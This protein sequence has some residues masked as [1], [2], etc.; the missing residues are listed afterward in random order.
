MEL[1]WLERPQRSSSPTINPELGPQVPQMRLQL[2]HGIVEVGETSK[3]TQSPPSLGLPS[4]DTPISHLENQLQPQVVPSP[5]FPPPNEEFGIIWD[6]SQDGPPGMVL[7]WPKRR[8]RGGNFVVWG[9]EGSKQP[10]GATKILVFEGK[11]LG[12]LLECADGDQDGWEKVKGEP[13]WGEG[14]QN[15]EKSGQSFGGITQSFE[16]LG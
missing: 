7:W 6:H 2:G 9:K 1:L 13:G 15:E 11:M 4:K 12:M 10:L 14:A 16:L 8:P 5:C 3:T